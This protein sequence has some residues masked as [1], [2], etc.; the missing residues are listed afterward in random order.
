MVIKRAVALY[1][2]DGF[3]ELELLRER[4]QTLMADSIHAET[5]RVLTHKIE[6]SK[7]DFRKLAGAIASVGDLEAFMSSYRARVAKE[8]LSAIN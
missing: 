7:T 1:M 4:Y 3:A 5:F 8:G 6:P 2:S